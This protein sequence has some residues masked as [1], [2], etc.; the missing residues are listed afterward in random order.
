MRVQPKLAKE[1][2]SALIDL[3]ESIHATA[4][5]QE[6][7]VIIR[8]TLLQE[9]YV[10]NSC[11]QTIQVHLLTNLNSYMFICYMQ[12][13]DLT[14]LDWS[15]ELWIAIHDNDEQ[16]ARLA[17]HVWEDNGLDVPEPYLQHL[18]SFLG[19][20][21]NIL[22]IPHLLIVYRASKWLCPL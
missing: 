13:F 7:D 22:I 21:Y 20:H 12:P 18:L 10:R 1:A 17:Q 4:T 6:I 11:L 8:G 2:S 9:V 16:N 19:R 3:G 15:P 5:R 14:D